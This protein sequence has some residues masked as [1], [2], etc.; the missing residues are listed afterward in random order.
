MAVAI[1][2][3]GQSVAQRLE[4]TDP[5]S[6][7]FWNLQNEIYSALIE[8]ISDLLLLV[9]RPTQYV[10]QPLSLTPNTVWQTVPT[11]LFLISNLY[12]TQGEIRKVSLYEMD[13][14]QASWGS[15]WENDVGDYPLRWFPI[16]WNKFGVHPACS[17]PVTVTCTAI[18]YA[19]ADSWPYSGSETIPF[20]DEFE[21]ALEL[22]A[23]A[24]CRLKEIGDDAM[25]GFTLYQQYLD[26]AKRL[27]QIEDR[28]DPLIFARVPGAVIRSS[29]IVSR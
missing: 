25:E 2:T 5:S 9:G 21:V 7:V 10:Q 3:L 14:T 4:E 11:G 20:H 23:T 24:Y 17:A 29:P 1:S 6:P 18:Q 13:Y 16:G 8:A 12:G 22:Y 15:D 28:R 26:L 19:T 27:S